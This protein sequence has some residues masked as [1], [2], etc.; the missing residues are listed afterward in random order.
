MEKVD[1]EWWRRMYSNGEFKN[2]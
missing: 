2:A 1:C